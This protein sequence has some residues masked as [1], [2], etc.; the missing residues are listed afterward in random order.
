MVQKSPYRPAIRPLSTRKALLVWLGCALT[1]WL[2]AIFSIY[3]VLQFGDRVVAVLT[4]PDGARV[5]DDN[6]QSMQDIAPA[7]GDTD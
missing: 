1:G 2:V 6:G 5:T 4:E 7:A 3:G